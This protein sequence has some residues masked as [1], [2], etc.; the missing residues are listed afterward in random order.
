MKTLIKCVLSSRTFFALP[1]PLPFS[2]LRGTKNRWRRSAGMRRCEAKGQRGQQGAKPR[3]NREEATKKGE[4]TF[5]E[6]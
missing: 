3:Q 5:E 2:T 4:H 1:I 6:F